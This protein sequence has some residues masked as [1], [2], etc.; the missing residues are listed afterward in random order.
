MRDSGWWHPLAFLLLFL[1]IAA[2]FFLFGDEHTGTQ[3]NLVGFPKL[4]G[5]IITTVVVVGGL[6]AMFRVTLGG[7]VKNSYKKPQAVVRDGFTLYIT[8]DITQLSREGVPAAIQWEHI[9]YQ[10]W[11]LHIRT[12]HWHPEWLEEAQAV[13]HFINHRT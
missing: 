11:L 7:K 5:Q 10:E 2:S 12:T 4:I 1:A 3:G 9:G 8:G 6:W 13:A